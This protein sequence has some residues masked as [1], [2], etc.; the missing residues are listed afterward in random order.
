MA[1][2]GHKA[3]NVQPSIYISIQVNTISQ[4]TL[5]VSTNTCIRDLLLFTSS[6]VRCPVSKVRSAVD[7]R[8]SDDVR[9]LRSSPSCRVSSVSAL[10]GRAGRVVSVTVAPASTTKHVQERCAELLCNNQRTISPSH[11]SSR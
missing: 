9:R 11:S 8:L 5:R 2:T 3:T 7:S 4:P 10:C 6:I 1:C